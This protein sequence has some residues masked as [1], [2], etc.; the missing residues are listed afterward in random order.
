DSSIHQAMAALRSACVALNL[1][2][3]LRACALGLRAVISE[4]GGGYVGNACALEL[5]IDDLVSVGA[6]AGFAGND[7][8]KLLELAPL[9][10]ATVDCAGEVAGFA[11]RLFDGVDDEAVG[12]G[13]RCVVDFAGAPG[14]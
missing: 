14:R 12:A 13:E 6:A 8:S 7:V 5:G 2:L 3:E 9:Q 11:G 4:L 10:Q 1:E